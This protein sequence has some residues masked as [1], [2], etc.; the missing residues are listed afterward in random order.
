MGKTGR[1]IVIIH[2]IEI[3]K[4]VQPSSIII[5]PLVSECSSI[6]FLPMSVHE[7]IHTQDLEKGGSSSTWPLPH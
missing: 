4:K 2:H 5:K 3:L 1:S 7:L 6:I